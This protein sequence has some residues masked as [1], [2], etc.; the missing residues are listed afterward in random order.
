MFNKLLSI[1]PSLTCTGWALFDIKSN[2]ILSIGK[3]KS[4]KEGILS[5]RLLDFQNKAILLFNSLNL[6]ENDILLCE[7]ATT[8]IDPRATIIVEQVRC[9]FEVLARERGV[10]VPGR[11][12]PRTVQYEIMGL[13]GSQI[14]RDSVKAIARETVKSLYLKVL[15]SMGFSKE[16]IDSKNN[17]DIIDAILIGTLG[18]TRIHSATTAQCEIASLFTSNYRRKR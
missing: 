13:K 18:L 5:D 1:D 6:L 4:K 15:T 16:K 14:D 12:N 2:E 8:M 3:I 17:Q 7:E 9:I 11:I 10:V